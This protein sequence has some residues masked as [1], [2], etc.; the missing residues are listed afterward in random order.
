MSPCST[1]IDRD[2]PESCVYKA[3]AKK[4]KIEKLKSTPSG[5]KKES[6]AKFGDGNQSWRP[7]RADWFALTKSITSLKSEIARLRQSPTAR[8]D[9][10]DNDLSSVS[11]LETKDCFDGRDADDSPSLYSSS[12]CTMVNG[13]HVTDHLTDVYLGSNSAPA[14]VAALQG[15][16]RLAR[17]PASA[18]MVDE[19]EMLPAFVLGN[20]SA[21]YPFVDLFTLQFGS[22]TKLKKL[23]DMIPDDAECIRLFHNYRDTAHVLFPGVVDI[24]QFELELSEF[25]VARQRISHKATEAELISLFGESYEGM[26]FVGL[27]LAVLASGSQCSEGSNLVTETRSQIFGRRAMKPLKTLLTSQSVAHTSV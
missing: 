26:H 2:H 7:T 27:L 17:S 11:S 23:Y 13:F 9:E 6:E 5:L 3:P 16:S 4:S 25:V 24:A 22:H 20:E 8:Q 14:L 21:M 10:F 18:L 19:S 15:E 12:D 1:C